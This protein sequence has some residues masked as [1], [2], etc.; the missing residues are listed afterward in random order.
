MRI[1]HDI[2]KSAGLLFIFCFIIN[3]SLGGQPGVSG[4]PYPKLPASSGEKIRLFTDRSI[5]CVNEKIYFTVGYTCNEELESLSWSN[6]LYVEL[7]RWNGTMLAGMK[8][9][10]TDHMTSAGMEIPGDILSGNYYLRAYTRWM[11]NY[12]ATEYAYIRVKIVNPFRSGTDEGPADSTES[13][14]LPAFNDARGRL[15]NGISCVTDKKEYE[16]GEEAEVELHI[17]SKDPFD[18]DSYFISVAKA[19]ITDTTDRY[20]EAGSGIA[21]NIPDYIDYLPEIRGITISGTVADKSTGLPVNDCVVSLSETQSGEYFA[22]YRSDERGRFVFSLP[23]MHGAH[24]FFI[25]AEI[26]AEIH[27]DKSY[28]NQAIKLPYIAFDMNS[29]ERDFAREVLINQQITDRFNRNKD[30]LTD[31]L[32]PGIKPLVFYGSKKTVYLTDKYI[33]LPD[34]KEFIYEVVLEATILN[35]RDKTSLISLRRPDNGYYLP[36]MLMDNIK[37]DDPEQLLKIPLTKIERVEVINADYVVESIKY[38]GIMSFYS[39]NKDFAGLELN[40]NSLF[41]SYDLFSDISTGFDF[42]RRP[43]DRRIPDRRILLYWNPDLRLPAAEK[44]RISFIT[45]DCTGNYMVFVRSKNSPGQDGIYG[46]C[47]FSVK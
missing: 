17:D 39:R 1:N 26:A 40:K 36:L 44:T 46:I 33:E 31:S 42:D 23:D 25:Q 2:I 27:I 45:S 4:F 43:S 41:F 11:R 47:H 24:D 13:P 8:L 21:A 34:V 19:G 7:I 29:D 22:T 18:F 9:K 32:H 15:I 35:D 3:L 6:V 10:L 14:G 5:Y 30:R 16:P 38:N 28:C 20:M 37:I 12:T